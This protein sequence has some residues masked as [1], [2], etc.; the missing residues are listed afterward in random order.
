MDFPAPLVRGQLVRRY[1]RFL[2]DVLLESGELVVAHCAN[3]GAMLGVAPEGGEV[4]LSP[5]PGPKRKLAWSWQ[6]VRVGDGLV[7]INTSWPNLL[8]EEAIRT[9]VIPELA[10]YGSLRREVRYGRNSRIDL[11]LEAEGRPTCYVEVKNVH[12]SR[13]DGLAEFP[14]CV[15]QRGAKHLL[16]LA[17]MVAGGARAVMLF[18]VQ[19]DDCDRFRTAED[20][21]PTYH[22]GL[23]VAIAAG[24]EVLVYSCRVTI[25]GIRIARKLELLA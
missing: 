20:F 24:V 12:L 2:A 8:A 4:W 22:A 14:D 5:A 13:G 11:L 3:P 1:K 15:T 25:E 18:V 6:L 7:G 23:K 10:G 9:G 16:E 21:D 17:D 19:R